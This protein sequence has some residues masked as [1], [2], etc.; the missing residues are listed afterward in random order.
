MTVIEINVFIGVLLAMGMIKLADMK[1]Y[2]EHPHFPI[3]PGLVLFLREADFKTSWLPC[4]WQIIRTAM[5]K[6]SCLK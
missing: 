3:Y 2:E 4:N 6:I 5:A 1:D